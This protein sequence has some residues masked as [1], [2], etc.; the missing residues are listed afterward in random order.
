M[1]TL[2]AERFFPALA[3]AGTLRDIGCQVK[4]KLSSTQGYPSLESMI[5][6]HSSTQDDE[7]AIATATSEEAYPN[8]VSV[9]SILPST[10]GSSSCVR[11]FQEKTGRRTRKAHNSFQ[12]EICRPQHG[13]GRL[14][15][16]RQKRSKTNPNSSISK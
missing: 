12:H 11:G 8:Y 4:P 14:R 1:N 15:L 3:N 16:R 13:H 6:K 10:E 2:P 5:N 7:N 9:T